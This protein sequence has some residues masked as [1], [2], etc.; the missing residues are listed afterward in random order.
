MN[1][2]SSGR[3]EIFAASSSRAVTLAACHGS[4]CSGGGCRHAHAEQQRHIMQR[5]N[6]H[7]V[8]GVRKIT[9]MALK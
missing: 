3:E 2:P 6:E 8:I 9:E 1:A 7:R 5:S 4:F